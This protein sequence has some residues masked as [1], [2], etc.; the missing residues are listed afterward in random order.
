[1][2]RRGNESALLKGWDGALAAEV[3]VEEIGPCKKRLKIQVPK[4]DLQKKL[5]ENFSKLIEE[6]ALPG[7][8]K[9]H[10]PRK[11]VEKR[12]G[13]DVKEDVKQKTMSE[14]VQEA[15][16][17]NELKPI[18]EAAY[19]NV[20]FDVE[21]A[22][23]FDVT[24]EV[25]P[26]FELPDYKG[27]KLNRKSAEPTEEDVYNTI[28]D[29]RRRAAILT[30]LE[31]TTAEKGDIAICD[32]EVRVND[33]VVAS[34]TNAEIAADGMNVVGISPEPVAK[35][36]IG[37]KASEK[38]SARMK[39]TQ[40]FARE[41]LRGKE[42]DV[43]FT[44]KEVKRAIM[45]EVNEDFAKKH[46]FDSLKEM[47]DYVRE[48]VQA[49]K[50][51]WVKL[52]LENQ[53]CEGL[54]AAVNFELPLDLVKNETERNLARRRIRLMLRGIS[55]EQIEREKD[56]LQAASEEEA[57]RNFRTYL[58]LD[59]IAE[60]EK[61]FATEDDVEERIRAMAIQRGA[62]PAQMK[63]RIESENG[64]SSLR[65]EIRHQKALD[66]LVS[67][68]QIV[69]VKKSITASPEEEQ[70]EKDASLVS[71]EPKSEEKKSLIVTPEEAARERRSHEQK[72]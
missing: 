25:M 38:R 66:F 49:R 65:S 72:K 9:G 60:K 53:A 21:K 6:V 37:C 69:D 11:L 31:N 7:F 23:S 47:N 24:F 40:E 12:F 34:A 22:L 8:R 44:V 68:A 59:K 26:T 32:Y 30:T 51:Q 61:V 62:T 56:K 20:E 55:H 13:D 3:K 29:M 14:S 52:D 17:K 54:L 41:D 70:E 10:V 45:P 46:Q 50:E 28:Q 1:M 36:L 39:L 42:A 64:M 57:V 48:R 67:Q 2:R 16:E 15:L 35:L 58:I 33:Q 63:S 27:L 19:E 71:S 5:E 4:E 43:Q 18:G